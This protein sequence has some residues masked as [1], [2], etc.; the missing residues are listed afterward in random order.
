[1]HAL[2]ELVA[3]EI[4]SLLLALPPRKGGG[5]AAEQIRQG[6]RNHD[7]ISNVLSANNE[8]SKHAP[9]LMH[10]G[11]WNQI[12]NRVEVL[13][14]EMRALLVDAESEELGF[15]ESKPRLERSQHYPVLAADA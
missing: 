2:K 6:L 8:E 12:S 9:Q 5:L 10:V 11:G 3:D 13:D 4:K 14:G 7:I 1:M 15:R